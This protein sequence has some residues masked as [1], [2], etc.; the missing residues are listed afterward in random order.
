M[1]INQSKNS[2]L[3]NNERLC[4][5]IFS[6]AKGL[7]FSKRIKDFGLFFIMPRQRIHSLHMWFVFYPI[8]ILF[9]DLNKKVVDLKFNFRPFSFYTP[10][11]KC[12][13]IVELPHGTIHSSRTTL[14][15]VISV[16]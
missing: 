9:L 1:I 7:M 12:K 3:V 8:D 16:E 2:V 6:H 15:D 13:Y 11:K 10:R 4:K 5:T 14:G